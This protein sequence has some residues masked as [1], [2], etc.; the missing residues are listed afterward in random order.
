MKKITCVIV[1]DLPACVRELENLL[2]INSPQ[3]E[4]LGTANNSKDALSLIKSKN[5]ELL[6]LDIE[7]GETDIFDVLN[8]LP[9]KNFKIIF[10]T[11]YDKYVLKALR[12]SAI[13][14][15]L[16]PVQQDELLAAIEKFSIESIHPSRFFESINT[17]SFNIDNAN[18]LKKI[19]IPTK[20]GYV[21]KKIDELIYIEA[22]SNYSKLYFKNNISYTMSRTLAGIEEL[23]G[24]YGFFRTHKTYLVNLIFIEFFDTESL[25]ISLDTGTTLPVSIRRKSEL[26]EVLKSV[27]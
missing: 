11:G 26:L 8:Q 27:F 12:L 3:I 14:Y 19:G 4:I 10:V 20:K 16:K 1:D 18:K 7:L 15:L 17:L 23:V 13:D 6:F 24:G 5:P 25:T 22:F 9:E 2:K 21:V